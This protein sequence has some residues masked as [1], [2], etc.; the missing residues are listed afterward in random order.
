M[1]LFN[2]LTVYSKTVGKVGAILECN[3]S[4][5]IFQLRDCRYISGFH[6]YLTYLCKCTLQ[7]IILYVRWMLGQQWLHIRNAV[8]FWALFIT[9]I[10]NLAV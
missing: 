7:S 2:M 4:N 10:V 5:L 8:S 9:I 3:V 1:I 6:R